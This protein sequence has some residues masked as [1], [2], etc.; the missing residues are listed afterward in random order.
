MTFLWFD[1]S[2][3]RCAVV[4]LEGKGD[5]QRTF[6]DGD[7]IGAGAAVGGYEGGKGRRQRRLWGTGTGGRSAWQVAKRDRRVVCATRVRAIGGFGAFER[8]GVEAHK[9]AVLAAI[10]PRHCL[11]GTRRFPPDY[12]CKIRAK[13]LN[14]TFLDAPPFWTLPF[15]RLVIDMFGSDRTK[16]IKDVMNYKTYFVF[17]LSPSVFLALIVCAILINHGWDNEQFAFSTLVGICGIVVGWLA[18]MLASPSSKLE[19]KKFSTLATGVIGFLTGYATQ[20]ILD[21]VIKHLFENE[22]IFSSTSAGAN[23]LIFVTTFVLSAIN[24][25]SYRAYLAIKKG[26]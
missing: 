1:T 4:E 24:G 17:V 8:V 2:S 9:F 5:G 10:V 14:V 21:P 7:L 12:G 19:E 22:I 26:I 23:V 13:A 16:T 11:Q 18:G 6:G 3:L 25:Y 20:K 15:L